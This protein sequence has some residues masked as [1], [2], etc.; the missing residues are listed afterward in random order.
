ML[1]VVDALADWLMK[2]GDAI[3]SWRIQERGK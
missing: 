2:A 3:E 1:A